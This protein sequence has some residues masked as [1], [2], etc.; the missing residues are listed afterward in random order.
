[1]TQC[2]HCKF[3]LLISF[4]RNE[5]LNCSTNYKI[6]S[7][8]SFYE[9]WKLIWLEIENPAALGEGMSNQHYD[10]AN[11]L[12][13]KR[14]LR[15]RKKKYFWLI[16]S[17]FGYHSPS[18]EYRIRIQTETN[19]ARQ[20]RHWNVPIFEQFAFKKYRFATCSQNCFNINEIFKSK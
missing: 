9:D 11:V 4:L 12:L 6:V 10:C 5:K 7:F 8:V 16:F 1:M 13:H 20:V 19:C 3:H 2:N 15:K 18:Q 17:F 14:I